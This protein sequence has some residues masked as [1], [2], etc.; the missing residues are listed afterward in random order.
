[1]QFLIDYVLKKFV[2]IGPKWVFFVP[3]FICLKYFLIANFPTSVSSKSQKLYL[4]LQA[5]TVNIQKLKQGSVNAFEI[6]ILSA[7]ESIRLPL[8]GISV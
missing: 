8:I 4:T 2:Q 6:T 1:M 7:I 5:V 3:E